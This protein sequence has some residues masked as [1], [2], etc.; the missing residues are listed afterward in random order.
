MRP[1]PRISLNGLRRSFRDE[2]EVIKGQWDIITQAGTTEDVKIVGES[3]QSIGAGAEVEVQIRYKDRSRVNLREYMYRFGNRWLL[4]TE[5]MVNT[6]LWELGSPAVLKENPVAL[7]EKTV[8]LGDSSVEILPP[9]DCVPEERR[10]GVRHPK[11]RFLIESRREPGPDFES[12]LAL[13]D[14]YA[15]KPG[16]SFVAERTVDDGPWKRRLLI[17]HEDRPD[18]EQVV[19]AI[20]VAAEGKKVF[21]VV[22]HSPRWPAVADI[23]E[24]SVLTAKWKP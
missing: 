8:R 19:H 14:A 10:L 15:K 17:V 5:R 20:L 24:K 12:G 9:K 7:A 16:H 21:V 18:G 2:P 23:V 11:L 4:R 13:A 22:G 6:V 1:P 3:F